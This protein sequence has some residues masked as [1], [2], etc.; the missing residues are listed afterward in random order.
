MNALLDGLLGSAAAASRPPAGLI[1]DPKGDV[2][3]EIGRLMARNSWQDRLATIDPT[4]PDRSIRW[5]PFDCSDNTMERS[6]RFAG[7]L[8]PL[9]ESNDKD[10]CF[11][12]TATALLRHMI[13]ILCATHSEV[14]ERARSDDRLGPFVRD[15]PKDAGIE[16]ERAAEVMRQD[17]RGPAQDTKSVV[18]CIVSNMLGP[19]VSP[20]HDTPFAGRSTVSLSD[21]VEEGR[22][23]YVHLPFA[24][25]DAMARV[26]ATFV[27][28]EAY[29]EG[30]RRPDGARPSFCL[31]DEFQAFFTLGGGRGDADAFGRTR[32]SNSGAFQDLNALDKQ[33]DRKEPVDT[34]LGTCA[35]QIVLRNTDRATSECASKLFGEHVET[36]LSFGATAR[37]G[38]SRNVG[39]ATQYGARVREASFA[40]R[41][42]PSRP[43]A[44]DCAE[45]MTHLG[46]RARLASVRPRGRGH[47]IV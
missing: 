14:Y 10:K 2:R 41:A 22:I 11:I 3:T 37:K 29:R 5:N 16:V 31:C 43:G 42:V 1:V 13:V 20:P 36:L 18:R 27:E 40:Q 28:L 12:D 38:A 23:V 24:E 33:T 30:L 44:V 21:A 34:L 19:F 25:A 45:S 39:G 17:W 4:D 15:L 7:V 6:G 8:G 35:T 46:A 32:R 9:S 47:P 26:V